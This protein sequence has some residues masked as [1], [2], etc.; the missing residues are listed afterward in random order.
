LLAL[1][2]VVPKLRDL[3]PI[4]PGPYSVYHRAGEWLAQNTAGGEQVLDLTD[5]SLYFSRQS[6]Y[7]FADVYQ[8]P[9]DMKTRWI[10]VRQGEIDG[11]R[12]YSPIVRE[13]IGGREPVAQLPG[14]AA[15]NQ[16]QIAI[17]DRQAPARQTATAVTARPGETYR[18]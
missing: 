13:L 9:T 1:F 12:P 3:G 5:W 17:Y 15:R 16:V 7:G 14:S 2:V 11:D 4:N 6:G 8:A 10:V 18:R